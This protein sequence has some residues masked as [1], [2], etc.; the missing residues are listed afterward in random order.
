M[1][2]EES[3]M[4]TD[5]TAIAS[6]AVEEVSTEFSTSPQNQA[7]GAGGEPNDSLEDNCSAAALK[8]L[9][10]LLGISSRGDSTPMSFDE[11]AAYAAQQR[12]IAY[13]WKEQELDRFLLDDDP[14]LQKSIVGQ[15]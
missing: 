13:L 15:T 3:P 9:K 10:T 8:G 12:Q 5:E 11:K 14:W 6:D 4:A 7:G 2:E 1:P